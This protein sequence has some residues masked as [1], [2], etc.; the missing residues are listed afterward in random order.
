MV[1][2]VRTSPLEA[3][4]FLYVLRQT[5]MDQAKEMQRGQYQNKIAQAPSHE[6][7]PNHRILPLDNKAALRP[8][9]CL[10]RPEFT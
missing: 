2:R 3:T 9:R 6:A 5:S 10:A 1:L 7:L 4:Y 8:R